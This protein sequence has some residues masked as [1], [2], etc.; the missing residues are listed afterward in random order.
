MKH[1]CA[2]CC[3]VLLFMVPASGQTAQTP[4]TKTPAE[5]PPA[6][7][8]PPPYVPRYELSGGYSY[9]TFN[10]T[11]QARIGLNGGYGSIEYNLLSRIGAAAEVSGGFKNQGLNGDLSIYSVMAGPQVYPFKHRRKLTPFMHFL[12]GEQ[13]YRNDYPAV[14][15]FPHA[16][17][18]DS[19]FSWEG[20]GGFDV[21]YKTHWQIRLIQFDYAPTKFLGSGTKTGYRASVGI[22]YRFGEKK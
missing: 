11:G 15:G 19:V 9:R 12:F 14:G 8:L 10:P 22:V 5:T 17:S 4:P 21:A 20:G 1:L 16:V 3:F 6:K 13:F 18:T 2:V 7:P